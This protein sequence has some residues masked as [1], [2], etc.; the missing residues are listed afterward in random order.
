MID[1]IFKEIP[2]VSDILI[3]EYDIDVRDHDDVLKTVMQICFKENL[4]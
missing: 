1:E 4:K 3:V 2:N